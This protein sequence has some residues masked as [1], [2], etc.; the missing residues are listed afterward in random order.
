M[1]MN[2]SK[3]MN[4]REEARH[5]ILRTFWKTLLTLSTPSVFPEHLKI[6]ELYDMIVRITY[7]M[8]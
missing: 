6:I 4:E 7:L 8:N 2:E 5:Y 1:V 3:R